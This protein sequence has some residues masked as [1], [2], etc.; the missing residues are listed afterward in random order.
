MKKLNVPKLRDYCPNIYFAG[1]T[2]KNNIPKPDK[3]STVH[4][5]L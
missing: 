3:K 1:G 2:G 4:T 5:V